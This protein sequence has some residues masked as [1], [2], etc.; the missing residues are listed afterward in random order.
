MVKEKVLFDRNRLDQL[1]EDVTVFESLMKD[2]IS[3]FSS[4]LSL[5]IHTES[6][7]NRLVKH[8]NE[9]FSESKPFTVPEIPVSSDIP[10]PVIKNDYKNKRK[11]EEHDNES[12]DERFDM[13]RFTNTGSIFYLSKS[14]ID[15]IPYSYIYEQSDEQLRTTDGCIYLDYVGNEGC[16]YYLIDYLKGKDHDLYHLAYGDQVQI[17][18][19]FEFCNVIIP[20]DLVFARERRDRRYKK[21]KEGDYV[22]LVING[23]ADNTVANFLI[24]SNLWTQFIMNYDD[25]FVNYRSNDESLYMNIKY[26]YIEYIHQYIINGYIN[27]RRDEINKIDK[28]KFM[29]EIV[30]LFGDSGKT[31]AQNALERERTFF[32]NSTIIDDSYYELF[33]ID[34]LGREKKWRLLFRASEHEYKTS[35]FHKY[36]DN[37]GETVTFIKHIGHNNQ[38]NIFGGYISKNWGSQDSQWGVYNSYSKEFLFT[39]SNEH[40]IPPTKY[41]YSDYH[42]SYGMHSSSNLGPTF[43]Y[44]DIKISDD[45]H[46]KNNSLCAATSFSTT[47]NPLRNSLF[48]NTSDPEK[49]NYFK[50]EDYEVWGRDE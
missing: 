38:L 21:Y 8:I 23:E 28:E 16:A 11:Y 3:M 32:I 49:D 17:L 47:N 44:N 18:D 42:T 35:E 5:G 9:C 31:A 14:I 1:K 29:K 2:V 45:C 4:V 19:L 22:D 12:E 15:S 6:S 13:I 50:V 26:E 24:K 40:N 36:C 27:M 25:G 46:N 41:E 34:W 43:G 39:L 33:L 10:D 30:V 7:V 37:Q 48:V 20:N